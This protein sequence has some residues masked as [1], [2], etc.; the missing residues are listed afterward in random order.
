MSTP[1]GPGR[2][3]LLEAVRRAEDNLE[4][5]IWTRIP[6]IIRFHTAM[7]EHA[8][9]QMREATSIRTESRELPRPPT[10]NA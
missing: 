4:R 9:S 5:A 3:Q 6:G 1:Q 7:L 8:R 10:P 2:E